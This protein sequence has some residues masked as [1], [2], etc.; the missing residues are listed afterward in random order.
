VSGARC[1]RAHP[2]SIAAHRDA[3]SS[4]LLTDYLRGYPRKAH[5]PF[6]YDGEDTRL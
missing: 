5:E 6:G 1:K 3:I 2:C 4:Q